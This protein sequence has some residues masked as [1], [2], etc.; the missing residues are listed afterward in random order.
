MIPCRWIF[1][2]PSFSFFVFTA[3][4]NMTTAVL[5]SASLHTEVCLWDCFGQ[6]CV[7][8]RFWWVALNCLAEV[9]TN[10]WA[11]PF[12]LKLNLMCGSLWKHVLLHES[13]TPS[14]EERCPSP[15]LAPHHCPLWASVYA[16]SREYICIL[17]FCLVLSRVSRWEMSSQTNCF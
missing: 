3:L 4:N 5:S 1:T 13:N 15:I 14:E 16:P 10:S 6:R 9:L 17:P 12:F 7:H 8:L 11:D 2:L